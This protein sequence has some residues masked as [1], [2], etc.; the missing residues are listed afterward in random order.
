MSSFNTKFMKL[1]LAEVEAAFLKVATPDASVV[2]PEFDTQ[3]LARDHFLGLFRTELNTRFSPEKPKEKKT[4]VP[5]TAVVEVPVAF[6]A[7]SIPL[8]ASPKAEGEKKKRGP[9]SEE[10]KAA[11]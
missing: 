8:P 5:K 11:M 9:M 10:A 1:V 7:V 2:L 3:E 4:K 6:S